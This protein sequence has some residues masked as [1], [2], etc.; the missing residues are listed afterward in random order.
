MVSCF[1]DFSCPWSWSL[2]T[3]IFISSNLYWLALGKKFL[4]WVM[5]GNS[6]A[7]SYLSCEHTCSILLGASE[8]GGF[9]FVY[10]PLDPAKLECSS[11]CPFSSCCRVGLALCVCPIVIWKAYFHCQQSVH[12][13]TATG[14]RVC[15]GCTWSMKGASGPAGG[16]PQVKCLQQLTGGLPDGFHEVVIRICVLLMCSVPRPGCCSPIGPL[17]PTCA[18]Y[19]SVFWMV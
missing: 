4:L 17:P 5:L 2:H 14:Q 16:N 1:L 3:W 12:R 6:E 7:F 9:G 19:D 10:L 8:V 18:V 13:G 15:R 11:L